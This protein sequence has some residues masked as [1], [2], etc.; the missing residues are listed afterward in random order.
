MP[1]ID[2]IA[3]GSA[4][5]DAGLWSRHSKSSPPD[6]RRVHTMSAQKEFGNSNPPLT[7]RE[8]I[9]GSA[10]LPV[11]TAGGGGYSVAASPGKKPPNIVMVIAD[12]CRWDAVGAYGQNSMGLTP[13]LDAMAQRGTLFRSHIVNQP[14][15]AP[16]RANL[17]TGQ[18]Q[19]RHGVWQNGLGLAPGAVTLA[20]TLREAGYTTNYIGKWHLA[21]PG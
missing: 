1:G 9:K 4:R 19:N 12:Q 10:A 14:V 17:F 21:R 2:I 3:A 13:N 16:S 8:F 15:C 11:L 20:T 6:R 18:Y 7:R 5:S